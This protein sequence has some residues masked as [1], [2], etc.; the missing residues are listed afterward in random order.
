[1]KPSKDLIEL[2]PISMSD[3]KLIKEKDEN[4]NVVKVTVE[5]PTEKKPSQS[6]NPE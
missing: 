2:N 4:G 5:A 1:M 6:S 3:L